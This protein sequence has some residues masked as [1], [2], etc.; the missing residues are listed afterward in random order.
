[1]KKNILLIVT[2]LNSANGICAQSV[3][4]EFVKNGDNVY[5]IANKEEQGE[6]NEQIKYTFVKPRWMYRMLLA[7]G[8]KK[9][10]PIIENIIKLADK[11]KLV[12][13]YPIWPLISPLYTRRIYKKAR[14][15][16][17]KNKI[18]IIIPVYTQI[19]TLLA[20][21]KIKKEFPSIQ[22]IPYF[23]DAL[24]GGYG[25]KMFS[26]EW[27]RKRGIKWE[28]KLLPSADKIIMMKSN[29]AHVRQ[30]CFEKPY[31]DKI[32]FLDI[33]LLVKPIQGNFNN[34]AGVKLVYVGSIPV[35]IRNPRYF[36]DVFSRIQD[37]NVRLSIIGTSTC[38]ELLKTYSRQ[39]SRIVIEGVVNH[40]KALQQIEQADILV[41]FGNNNPSMV[42]SKIFEY[43]SYGKPI[44]STL[45]IVNE[46]SKE[47]LTQYP[48]A[49]L[50][51][52]QEQDIETEAKKLTAWI[53]ESKGRNIPFTEIEKIFPQNTPSMF[54]QTI[55]E[56]WRTNA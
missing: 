15:I 54:Y 56:G 45:P 4:N 27:V 6:L 18:D 24:S 1:M 9:R 2:E 21:K 11:I 12:L 50:L 51:D 40:I 44:I 19:D 36:L 46:P 25:P 53:R 42:P 16:C 28:D 26:K 20:A 13:T 35:H 29:Q 31:Y 47:Y 37:E 52:E 49:Y 38:E 3:M 22:Y 8:R 34:A 41:N 30:F 17:Q 48:L 10:K 23:L 33:P 39:D 55:M 7:R 43:M 14:A 5:C 32:V